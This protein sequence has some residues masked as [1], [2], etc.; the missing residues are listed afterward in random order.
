MSLSTIRAEIVT[1]LSGVAGVGP[2]IHDYERYAAHWTDYLALFKDTD[3]ILGWVITRE[4]TIETEVSNANNMRTHTF[5]IRGFLSLDDSAATEKIFQ[6]L[7]EAICDE[8][9]PNIRLNDT[10]FDTFPIQVDIQE[11]RMF[12]SVLVHYTEMR[13]DIQEEIQWR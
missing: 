10:A 12:G 3:K 9:R 8:F 6:D 5:V 13:K 2:N 4:K 11:P 1:I 7:I